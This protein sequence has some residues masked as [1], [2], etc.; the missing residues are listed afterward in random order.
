MGSYGLKVLYFNIKKA[1]FAD[2]CTAKVRRMYDACT[3]HLRRRYGKGIGK[4]L[5]KRGGDLSVG[6]RQDSQLFES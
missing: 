2:A 1:A 6:E 3:A 4:S 5:G